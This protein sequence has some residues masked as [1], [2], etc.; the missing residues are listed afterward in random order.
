MSKEFLELWFDKLTTW[1]MNDGIYI[2]SMVLLVLILGRIGYNV[3]REK[4]PGKK[5]IRL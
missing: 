3:W 5:Q 1:F 2:L 4:H